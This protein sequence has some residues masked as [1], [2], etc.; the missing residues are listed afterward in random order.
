MQPF[1]KHFK[2]RD[3]FMFLERWTFKLY[4]RLP[5]HVPLDEE[6][7]SPISIRPKSF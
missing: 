7:T 6:T 4:S 3:F 5:C 1:N 2:I